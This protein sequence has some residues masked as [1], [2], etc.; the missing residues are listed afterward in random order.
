MNLRDISADWIK[1][2]KRKGM[3][4]VLVE[5]DIDMLV[6]HCTG[7]DDLVGADVDSIIK[8]HTNPNHVCNTGCWSICYHYYIENITEETIVW[9]TLPHDIKAF[10]AGWWNSRS[11]GIVIDKR[12]ET[13][14]S[15]S[16]REALVELLTRLC[17]RYSLNPN[18]A[19]VGHRN[20]YWTGWEMKNGLF[21]AKKTCPGKIDDRGLAGIREDV[22]HKLNLLGYG[23][24]NTQLEGIN[25]G[26][27]DIYVTADQYN[28]V[29]SLANHIEKRDIGQF[30]PMPTDNTGVYN[31]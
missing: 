12:E 24:V 22:G 8:Y 15:P 3:P 18:V 11:L 31:G 6:I 20:L 17:V 21:V 9:K 5:S 7:D 16:K 10:H 23:F 1:H 26:N 14:V 13:A 27:G 29:A 2:K 28:S 30:V 4:P 19:I 25:K